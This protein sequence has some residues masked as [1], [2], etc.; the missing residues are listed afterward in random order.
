MDQKQDTNKSNALTILEKLKN[1]EE[2]PI[3]QLNL[4]IKIAT[5]TNTSIIETLA[6][7][8]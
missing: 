1:Q 7:K 3:D 8:K 5:E 6:T 2:I 4:A